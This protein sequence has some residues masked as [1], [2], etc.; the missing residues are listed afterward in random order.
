MPRSQG[1][2]TQQPFSPPVKNSS[3]VPLWILLAALP[4]F[5]IVP[6]YAG[7]A[8]YSP[9]MK[10]APVEK[11]APLPIHV[12]DSGGGLFITPVAYLINPGAEGTALGLPSF[13]ASYIKLGEKNVETVCLTETF[14]RRVELGYSASRFGIGTLVD[15]VRNV[16]LVSLT[17]SLVLHSFSARVLALQENS[18]GLPLPAVTLGATYKYNDGISDINRQLFGVLG[19]IG[20]LDDEGVDFVITATKALPNLFGRPL[21]ATAGL[22]V[23][24]AEQIGYFGFGDTYRPTFEGNL[25]Y[26]ITDWM[27]L[28]GEF[29]GNANAYQQMANPYGGMLVRRADN[30]W[31]VGLTLLFS[32]HGTVTFGWGRLGSI[33]NTTENKAV[34]MEVKYEF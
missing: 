5:P 15:D 4:F 11:C 17:D 30:W 13:S 29:R 26:G 20:Y 6:V 1:H 7:D 28:A 9:Q 33:I 21:I 14:F 24:K 32:R 23:S 3:L 22:R 19:S 2:F 18:F 10:E 16:M 31:A 8:A 27:W 34:G 12:L 25:A